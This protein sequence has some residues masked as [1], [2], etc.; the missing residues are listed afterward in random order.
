MPARE[1]MTIQHRVRVP[2]MKDM[3]QRTLKL[4]MS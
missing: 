2:V 3:A 1:R 4:R